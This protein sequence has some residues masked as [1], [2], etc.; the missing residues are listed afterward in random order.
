M[1]A[2]MIGKSRSRAFGIGIAL[3]GQAVAGYVWLGTAFTFTFYARPDTPVM[4]F[5]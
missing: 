4:A 3:S 1:I 2:S 5:A